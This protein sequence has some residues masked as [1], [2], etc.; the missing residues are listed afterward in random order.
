MVSSTRERENLQGAKWGEIFTYFYAI[1][2]KV[3]E[4]CRIHCVACQDEFYVNNSHNVK[5][6]EEHAFDFAPHPLQ[7]QCVWTFPMKRPFTAYAF[8]P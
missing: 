3:A 7:S 8:F 5:E 1:I 2:I 4:L 6:N